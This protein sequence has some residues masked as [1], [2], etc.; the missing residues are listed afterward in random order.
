MQLGKRKWITQVRFRNSH[1][2]IAGIAITL[3][4]LTHSSVFGQADDKYEAAT[5]RYEKSLEAWR[6]VYILSLIHI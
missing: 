3:V 1:L 6:G 5:L 4:S 2:I